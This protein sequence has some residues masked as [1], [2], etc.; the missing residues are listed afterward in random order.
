MKLT[1]GKSVG[2]PDKKLAKQI[3][4]IKLANCSGG[5]GVRESHSIHEASQSSIYSTRHSTRH[6]ALK[7]DAPHAAAQN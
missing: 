5:E 4:I 2:K 7:L 6:F 1:V 3:S